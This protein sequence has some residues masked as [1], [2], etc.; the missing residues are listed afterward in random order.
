MS[1]QDKIEQLETFMRLA[2]T[3]MKKQKSAKELDDDFANLRKQL[4]DQV[5]K[6][7]QETKKDQIE[8]IA[9]I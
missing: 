7:H 5:E 2:S 3:K 6:S 4:F 8:N 1:Y 9:S